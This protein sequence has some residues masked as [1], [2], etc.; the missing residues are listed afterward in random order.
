MICECA[1][2]AR[3]SNARRAQVAGPGRLHEED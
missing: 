2:L 1:F 3:A